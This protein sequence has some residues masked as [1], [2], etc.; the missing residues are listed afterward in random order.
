LIRFYMMNI[1]RTFN[2]ED[3]LKS[4]IIEFSFVGVML[5]IKKSRH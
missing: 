4:N 3:I 2:L 1:E 5:T